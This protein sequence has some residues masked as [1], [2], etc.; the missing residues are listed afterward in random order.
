[1]KGKETNPFSFSSKNHTTS[2]IKDETFKVGDFSLPK[3]F[4]AKKTE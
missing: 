3:T 1:M 4:S 2:E